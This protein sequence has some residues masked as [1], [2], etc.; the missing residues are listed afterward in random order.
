MQSVYFRIPLSGPTFVLGFFTPEISQA[1][2]P[3]YE[4]K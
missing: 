2:T 4:P 3:D 1:T